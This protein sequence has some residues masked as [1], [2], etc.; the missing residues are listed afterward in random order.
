MLRQILAKLGFFSEKTQPP[1]EMANRQELIEQF[2]LGSKSI[3]IETTNIC[4]ARCCFC[5]HDIMT[6]PTGIMSMKVFERALQQHH[7]YAPG[8]TIMLSPV[9]GDI[10][11]DTLLPQRI[12]AL[13][14]YPD[15]QIA[16]FSNII[17][18]SKWR[19]EEILPFLSRLS[20]LAISVGP[21]KEDYKTLF[22]VE[23]FDTV[24]KNT[25]RLVS[26]CDQMDNPPEFL[27]NGRALGK[28][29]PEDP[30]LMRLLNRLNPNPVKWTREYKD[31]GGQT[32]DLPE[33]TGVIRRETP[34]EPMGELCILAQRMVV[35]FDGRVGFCPCSDYDARIVIGDLARDTIMSLSQSQKRKAILRGFFAGNRPGHCVRCT[36]FRPWQPQDVS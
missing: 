17:G 1:K 31:W 3:K 4:N 27:I 23:A 28:G 35:F 22:G 16:S 10:L 20:R 8:G 15:F 7:Q 11:M 12:K 24:K 25:S 34:D 5:P 29:N 18:L 30:D 21:N 26:L 6:R 13:E 14:M 32:S 9:V 19:D 2:I 36:F 33:H